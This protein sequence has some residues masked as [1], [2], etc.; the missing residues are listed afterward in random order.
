MRQGSIRMFGRH[1]LIVKHMDVEGRLDLVVP[2]TSAAVRA[3]I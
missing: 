1:V 3:T 2:E